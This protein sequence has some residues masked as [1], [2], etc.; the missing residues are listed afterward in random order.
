MALASFG[1]LGLVLMQSTRLRIST[2]LRKLPSFDFL[3]DKKYAIFLAYLV[4]LA[5]C[6]LAT[7]MTW[8]RAGTL[9]LLITFSISLI[10]LFL[11]TRFTDWSKKTRLLGVIAL[12]AIAL[13]GFVF[14]AGGTISRLDQS[15][16]D[17]K[18]WCVAK[19]TLRAI[20]E[21]PFLGT[22]LGTYR[23]VYPLYRDP[24]C[25][26]NAI[27]DRAH[28]SLLEGYLGLGLPFLLA[29]LAVLWLS[30]VTLSRGL[31]Q[32]RRFV[33]IPIVLS[34][35]GLFAALHS[36]VDF[37]LQIHGIAIFFAALWGSG[38]ASCNA[39]SVGAN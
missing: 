37:P 5:I 10:W 3:D 20:A 19:F 7:F 15:A 38:L 30:A 11:F 13:A 39:R 12:M 16:F 8:S 6:I 9:F 34:G 2:V 25:G 24:A 33:F 17:E 22:G 29:L 36:L 27:W 18:R 31:R 4:L 28:N 23:E 1:V 32:R 14:F 21:H 35:M 26:V